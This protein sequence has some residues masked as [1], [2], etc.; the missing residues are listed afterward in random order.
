MRLL[1]SWA[2]CRGY[3]RRGSLGLTDI[4]IEGQIAGSEPEHAELKPTRLPH[5]LGHHTN[6][7]V[8]FVQKQIG[9]WSVLSIPYNANS[10]ILRTKVLP[11][12]EIERRRDK[13]RIFK[14][15][16]SPLCS[17][18]YSTMMTVI[19]FSKDNCRPST[20][21]RDEVSVL[22]ITLATLPLPGYNQPDKH[23]SVGYLSMTKVT[24]NISR[25]NKRQLN[26]TCNRFRLPLIA[27]ES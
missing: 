24:C 16:S 14:S 21:S 9:E 17:R 5:R 26:P 8:E 12:P 18:Q 19:C 2:R 3:V 6:V 4:L 10:N 27:L 15:R 22:L 13:T 20:P 25:S 11:L 23:I 1:L 7:L